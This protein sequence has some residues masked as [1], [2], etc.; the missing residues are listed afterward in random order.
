MIFVAIG[1]FFG[2][3][4]RFAVSRKI[5]HKSGFPIATLIVNLFGAFL[6]GL[7]VGLQLKGQLYALA[8]VGFMGAFTTFSTFK[9][10]LVKFKY[11]KQRTFFYS[12]LAISYIGGISLAYIGIM[13]GRGI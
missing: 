2:A 6:L 3:I 5:Q 1:G 11:A 9:L 4:S 8:G 13:L 12:Y 7:F 10:E